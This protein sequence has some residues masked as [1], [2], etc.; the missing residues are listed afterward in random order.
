MDNNKR[1]F[2][3]SSCEKK[4]GQGSGHGMSDNVKLF[5]TSLKGIIYDKIISQVIPNGL[6]LSNNFFLLKYF[7]NL[8]ISVWA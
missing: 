5:S 7:E 1:N 6:S 4:S 2:P 8:S 3:K